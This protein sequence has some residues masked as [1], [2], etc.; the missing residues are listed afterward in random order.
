MIPVVK[1]SKRLEYRSDL[2]YIPEAN[3]SFRKC[4]ENI[5]QKDHSREHR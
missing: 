1:V 4:V 2:V 5:H 3:E